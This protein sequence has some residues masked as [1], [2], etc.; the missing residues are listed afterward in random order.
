MLVRQVIAIALLATLPLLAAA[1]SAVPELNG[2]YEKDC[3]PN[4]APAFIIVLPAPAQNAEFWLKANAP[5]YQIAGYWPHSTE[6]GVIPGAASILL[7]RKSPKLNCDKALRPAFPAVAPWLFISTP[8][9]RN[10]PRHSSA[11]SQRLWYTSGASGSVVP[12]THPGRS[13]NSPLLKGR[14]RFRL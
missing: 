9:R 10:V 12:L 14:T 2:S 3:A 8:C 1:R 5:L 7:C 13:I 6:L 4:D 11:V